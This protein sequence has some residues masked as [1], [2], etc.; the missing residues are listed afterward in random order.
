M[1]HKGG[2]SWNCIRFTVGSLKEEKCR[3]KGRDL[4]G[5]ERNKGVKT[6]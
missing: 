2:A 1:G 4:G 3:E 5:L 6:Q